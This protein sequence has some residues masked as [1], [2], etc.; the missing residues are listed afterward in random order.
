V[1]GKC[2][3]F[4]RNN[5]G[6][7][8]LN[9]LV[10]VDGVNLGVEL[11]V[12]PFLASDLEV[13]FGHDEPSLRGK[14][15]LHHGDKVFV[16]SNQDKLEIALLCSRCNDLSESNSQSAFVVVVKIYGRLVKCYASAVTVR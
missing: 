16:V 8:G 3:I 15:S 12:C 9:Q 10:P 2:W 14:L 13:F 4:H 1:A 6:P 11:P 5:I 7:D